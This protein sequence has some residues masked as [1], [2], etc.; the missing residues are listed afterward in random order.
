MLLSKSAMMKWHPRNKKYYKEKEYPFTKMGDEFEVKVEDLTDGSSAKINVKCDCEDCK[1]PYL[2]P[3]TYN[4]YNKNIKND[5]K[6]YCRNC[7]IKLFSGEVVRISRL[8]NGKSF[9]DWCYENLSKYEADKIILRW[10]YENNINKYGKILSPKDVSCN[11]VGINKKGYWFKCLNYPE[12]KSEQKHICDLTNR[13]QSFINCSQCNKLNMTHNEISIYLVDKEDL[14]KYSM[15]SHD[16][17]LTKC[18][19]CGHIKETRVADLVRFGVRCPRCSFGY[20]PEKFIFSMLEQISNINFQTQLSKTTFKWCN[21]YKYD[22]YFYNSFINGI[23]ETHGLQHYEE[24]KLWGSLSNIQN[25]DKVKELLAIN[26]NI[27]NYIKIDCR[28]SEME[29]IRNSVL[30]SELPELLNFKE[31]DIN[32]IQCDKYARSGI[33]KKI[34]EMWNNDVKNISKIAEILKINKVT[35]RRYLNQGSCLGWTNY[36]GQEEKNKNY[37]IIH[38]INSVKVICLNTK[39][40]FNS[41]TSASKKYNINNSS[42]SACCLGH[43]KSAGK[44][45]ETKERFKWMYYKDYL[46]IV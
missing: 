25:N 15:G 40:I 37:K 21:K 46:K 29:W 34:C 20:Y 19:E 36:N 1:N 33:T 6:Y 24:N 7:T 4:T 18:L 38:E 11:S 13:K 31:E 23:I 10:D 26:N 32:W 2:P 30:N 17:V 9:Y 3:M 16:M 35:V 8:K 27:N 44:N 43:R 39:E 22:F 45:K 5:G 42:I 41:L 28:K 14:Y 12:H